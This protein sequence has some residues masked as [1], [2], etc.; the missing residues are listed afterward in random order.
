MIAT[1]DDSS[2]PPVTEGQTFHHIKN[3][4]GALA[5]TLTHAPHAYARRTYEGI[6][7]LY[8]YILV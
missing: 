3:F 6:A 7:H 1:T 8:L 5:R 2:P 4:A